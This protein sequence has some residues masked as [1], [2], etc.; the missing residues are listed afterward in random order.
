MDDACVAKHC[1][2]I[3]CVGKSSRSKLLLGI[4]TTT[5]VRNEYRLTQCESAP[6]DVDSIRFYELVQACRRLFCLYTPPSIVFPALQPSRPNPARALSGG[7]AAAA[8]S[9]SASTSSQTQSTRSI[10]GSPLC[11]RTM[12]TM[13][14]TR[15]DV[16]PAAGT[17]GGSTC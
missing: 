7:A 9:S 4:P 12:M 8:A 3:L 17:V 14:M 15:R 16:P 13:T 11:S 1:A 6:R 10:V 2:P 5:T